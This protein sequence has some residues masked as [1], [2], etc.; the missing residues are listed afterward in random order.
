VA[1]SV[2]SLRIFSAGGLTS[3]AGTVGP[4]VPAGLVYVLR[5]IDAV[6]ITGSASAQLEVLS[7][8]FQPIWFINT[9]NPQIGANF[10]WRGRQVFNVGEQIG[11]HAFSGTWSIMASGYQLTLP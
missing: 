1:R 6:E 11:F 9:A 7:P 5:D 2:Y 8:N 4:V 10:Q 3:S